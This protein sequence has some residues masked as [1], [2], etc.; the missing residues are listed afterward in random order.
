M[1]RVKEGTVD[2]IERLMGKAR[3]KNRTVTNSLLAAVGSD[4]QS[5]GHIAPLLRPAPRAGS[6]DD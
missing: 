1:Q 2:E 5:L 3:V 6:D 4:S